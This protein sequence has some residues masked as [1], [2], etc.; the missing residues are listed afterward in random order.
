[1]NSNRKVQKEKNHFGTNNKLY[2]GN[3]FPFLKNIAGTKFTKNKNKEF[4][5]H[6]PTICDRST[7]TSKV[8]RF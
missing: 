8:N 2:F 4:L 1:M 7:H 6:A 3:L 5:T